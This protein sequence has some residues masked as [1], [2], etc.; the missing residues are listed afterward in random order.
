MKLKIR[1]ANPVSGRLTYISRE[2]AVEY[3]ARGRAQWRN[4]RTITFVEDH[5]HVSATESALV[6]MTGYDRLGMMTLKQVAG[7]PVIHPEKLLTL[8]RRR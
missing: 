4:E 2:S 5:N 6:A 3:V 8:S 1:V 7:V